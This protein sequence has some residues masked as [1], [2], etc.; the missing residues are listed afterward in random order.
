[1]KFEWDDKKAVKNMKKHG[2]SFHEAATVFGDPLALTFDDPDHSGD[3][4]RVLTFGRTRTEKLVI[5]SHTQRN[6]SIRIIS[7]RLMDKHERNIYEE[8]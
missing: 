2:I 1:M 3:E 7:A 4:E 5:A 8:G 6:G